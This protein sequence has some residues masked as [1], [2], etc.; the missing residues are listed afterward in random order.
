MYDGNE[1][2][3]LKLKQKMLHALKNLQKHTGIIVH[4]Y[5]GVFMF[6][7]GCTAGVAKVLPD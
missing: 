2:V 4:T 5:T 7:Q 1:R 3:E 6:M